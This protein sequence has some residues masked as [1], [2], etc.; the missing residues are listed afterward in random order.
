MPF[1]PVNEPPFYTAMICRMQEE[2]TRLFQ[3]FINDDVAA[4]MTNKDLTSLVTPHLH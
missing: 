1:G 4:V 2:W 3:L